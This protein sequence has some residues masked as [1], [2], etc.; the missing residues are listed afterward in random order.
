MSKTLAGVLTSTNAFAAILSRPTAGRFVDN[1][2]GK[3]MFIVGLLCFVFSFFGYGFFLVFPLL[4]LARFVYGLGNSTFGTAGNTIATSMIPETKMREGVGYFGLS[5]SMAQAVG[6][7]AAITLVAVIGY[8]Y[9]FLSSSLLTVMSFI[10]FML[11][12]NSS[13]AP[14]TGEKNETEDIGSPNNDTIQSIETEDNDEKWWHKIIEKTTVVHSLIIFITD[15][16]LVSISTFLII[17]AHEVGIDNFGLYFTVQ[18]ITITLV[19]MFGAKLTTGKMERP[20]LIISFIGLTCALVGVFF[21]TKLWHFVLIAIV[22]GM[23]MGNYGMTLQTMMI[24]ASP[25]SKRGMANSSYFLSLEVGNAIA[26]PIWGLI[27]DLI[28]TRNIYLIA[29]WIPLISLLIF[30][31]IVSPRTAKK[32][33]EKT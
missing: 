27:S 5:A 21:S 19:R 16:S 3:L 11:I 6:P 14:M 22:Y 1:G 15:V 12:R 30:V 17:R 7:P 18:A 9:H 25:P 8:R 24:L 28:G 23:C 29:A 31:K 26:G 13:I 33:L 32:Q 20:A 10:M 4:F 2:R